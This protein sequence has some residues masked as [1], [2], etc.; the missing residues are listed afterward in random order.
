MGVASN[1]VDVKQ[2]AARTERDLERRAEPLCALFMEPSRWPGA[3]LDI[4]WGEVIRNSAH[5][6]ICACSIDQ[7]GDAVM[8]RFAEADEIATGLARR[9]VDAVGRSMAAAGPTIVNPSARARGGLVEL[10]L[11]GEGDVA[12]GQILSTRAAS[13]GEV[14]ITGND[15]QGDPGR[16][17]Q[18]TDRR[19][20]LRER[21]RGRGDRSRARH[22][23]AR[24]RATPHRAD[25]RGDQAR[26]VRA[27]RRRPRDDGAGAHRATAQPAACSSRA[28]S[29]PGFGWTQWSEAPLTVEPVTATGITL[30]QRTGD[31]R[32][33]SGRRH[34]L[35]QRDRRVRPARGRRRS[36]RHLQLLPA[37]QRHARRP[38]RPR[39]GH[40]RRLGPAARHSRGH[41]HVHLAGA[42]RRQGA[43]PRRLAPSRG[44]DRTG[45]ARGRRPRAGE[46]H[47]R[48]PEPRPPPARLVPASAAGDRVTRRVRVRGRRARPRGR[49]RPHRTRPAHVP[50]APVRQRGRR[51]C[52]ARG[53]ARVRA[54]RRRPR[55]CAHPPARR[56]GCS[57]ASRSPTGRFPP[58]RRS[59]SR[60]RRCSDP[61]TSATRSTSARPTRSRWSTPRSSRSRSSWP[62]AA[63]TASPAGARSTIT[64]AEVSALQRVAGGL[65]LRV[66]NPSA[67]PAQVSIGDRSGWLVDLRARPLEQIDGG[68]ELGPWQIAT[69]RLPDAGN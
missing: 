65:E 64:G 67:Q 46:H 12:G 31:H 50:V 17:P 61:S 52:R 34:L 35:D 8:H 30:T 3:L 58:G 45:A 25:D 69:I 6:S 24:R 5:D 32:G 66:F 2:A 56:P 11:P 38:A 26:P 47:L 13:Q 37:G 9:A 44:A 51:H 14:T 16:D 27:S 4:A 7:V 63:A 15:L 49:G 59:P 33:R 43:R 28:E 1:R 39:R 40:P 22:R 18:P 21:H 55:A 48:Q 53:P 54:C 29:V 10:R 42:D 20:H 19:R 68:F 62:T 41:P 23:A 60:G 36:R 57:R